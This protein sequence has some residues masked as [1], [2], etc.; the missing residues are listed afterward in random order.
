MTHTP[1]CPCMGCRMARADIEPI[2]GA[3]AATEV[4]TDETSR[5]LRLHRPV[6]ADRRADVAGDRSNDLADAVVMVAV[7]A[8]WVF[9]LAG[10]IGGWL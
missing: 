1:H 9:V 2:V 6:V 5:T 3:S 10:L 8:A 7:Y 4:G